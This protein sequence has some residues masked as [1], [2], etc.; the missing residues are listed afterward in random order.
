MTAIEARFAVSGYLILPVAAGGEQ[1]LAGLLD[2]C[3]FV[4]VRKRRRTRVERGIWFDDQRFCKPF[5]TD[6][7]LNEIFSIFIA[8][9]FV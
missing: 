9:N 1:R 5:I 3:Q 8:E 7:V 2:V 6:T 4:F